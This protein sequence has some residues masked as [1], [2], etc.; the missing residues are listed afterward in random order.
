[1]VVL[2]D[3]NVVLNHITGR[4]DRYQFSSR[5]IVT[6]CGQSRLNGYIAFHSVS[7]IWYALKIPSEQKRLWLKDI[8]SILT[9]TGA[10]HKQVMEAIENED[11]RDFEDCLQDECAQRVHADYLIT[12]NKKDFRTAKTRV[13]TPDE[14]LEAFSG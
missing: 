5:K 3:A 13:V 1:M 6:L 4:D 2:L 14:F 12:C 8:C 7:I 10:S 9:V 11:F